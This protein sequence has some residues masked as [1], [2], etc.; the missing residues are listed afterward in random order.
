[1]TQFPGGI[2]MELRSFRGNV[3][4]SIGPN[5]ELG[6]PN[7]TACHLDIPMRNCSLYLDDHEVVKNGQIVG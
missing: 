7:D 6:G 5:S 1:L 2:G 4:F 3:M